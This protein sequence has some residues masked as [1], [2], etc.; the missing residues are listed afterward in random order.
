VLVGFVALWAAALAGLW[1]YAW[2]QLGG[3]TIAALDDDVDPLGAGGAAAPA[4]STTVLGTLTAAVDPTIPR[5]PELMASPALVQV[6]GQREQPAVLVLPREL[7]VAVDGHGELTL[8]EVQDQGGTDLMVRAVTDYTG[9]RVDHAV[10]LSIDALPL[11]IERFDEVEVC[12]PDGCS[13]PTPEQ[14]HLSL[15]RSDDDRVVHEIIGTLRGI[16]QRVDAG[17]VA[18]S[19]LTAKRVV[20]IVADEVHTDASLRGT[21]LL[22]LADAFASVRDVDLDQVPV[23]A[24]PASGELLVLEEPAAVRFQHLREGTGFTGE[25]VEDLEADLIADV[26]VALL[27][28]AGV[29]GLA[30]SVQTRLGAAGYVVVGTGNAPAFDRETTSVIYASGDSE[31]AYV[32]ALLAEE[33]GGASLEPLDQ[34]PTYEGDPVDILVLLGPDQA[35]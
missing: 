21:T 28:A 30:G 5:P 3:D 26:E 22:T 25:Q 7:S 8:G 13:T 17:F 31:V 23:L 9:V 4:T 14:L 6:G 10:S 33:L 20:D 12:R 1:S 18:R 34:E 29:D 35:D 11:L 16:G 27:N 32:A 19:P 15:A 2:F 24:D